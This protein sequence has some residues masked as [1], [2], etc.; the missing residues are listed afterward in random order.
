MRVIR[1]IGLLF[2][3]LL[4]TACSKNGESPEDTKPVINIYVYAPDKPMITRGGVGEVT[5]IE[6]TIDESKI[7]KLQ[8]WVFDAETK[9]LVSYY[10]PESVVNLNGT[11]GTANYQL[12]LS[13]AF[14]QKMQTA[15]E[16]STPKPCVDV[17]IVAN[18]ASCGMA[19]SETT[20]RDVL[21]AAMIRKSEITDYFGLT[22]LTDKVPAT[23]LPMS[24]VLRGVEVGGSSP[25]YKL[26]NVKLTRAVSKIRFVFCRETPAD[27]QTDIP[28]KINSVKLNASMIPTSEYLFLETGEN[29][30]PHRV[31]AFETGDAQ[32]FLPAPWD[33]IP[34]NDDPLKYVY[35]SQSA[36]DYEDLIAEGLNKT[37]TVEGQE[38]SAPELK[39]LGPYYLRE[40]DKLLQGVITYQKGVEAEKTAT[41]EMMTAGDFSRNHTWTVYAYYSKSGLVAVTV[42]VKDWDNTNRSH[43]V[44]N[45]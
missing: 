29:A 22:T 36:Q 35:Q 8:I 34:K 41:F 21:E 40:S 38:V 45:W 16:Q 5:P 26:Q 30:K 4:L 44:Y 3:V 23:G 18:A 28:V 43:E 15:Q 24:G 12:S 42:A 32:E 33:D 17:Y 10:S 19:F 9:A 13:E 11:S 20:S 25:V 7:T 6:N 14:A 1:V 37:V 27:D 2:I 39:Q 31:G